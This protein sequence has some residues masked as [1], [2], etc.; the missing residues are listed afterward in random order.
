MIDLLP[1]LWSSLGAGAD[2]LVFLSHADSTHDAAARLIDEMD[3][4]EASLGPTVLLAVRQS[5]GRGRGDHTWTSP[6]GGLYLSW[7]SSGIPTSRVARLPMVAAAAAWQALASV[8]LEG[9][10]IKWPNDILHGGR[11]LAGLL[12]TARHGPPHWATVSL[13][14]NLASAPELAADASYPAGCLADALGPRTWSAWVEPIVASFVAELTKALSDPG[15][16]LSLWRAALIHR[17]G[18]RVAVRL[19]SG[20]MVHGSFRGVTADGFLRLG[21]G[22]SERVVSTGDVYPALESAAADQEGSE[23]A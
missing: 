14:V 13:G 20:E 3:D 19:A 1:R 22:D 2:N 21:E 15:P 6:E 23:T 11:K 9:H 7:L 5:A 8:G 18:D 4:D 10:G 12:V 16:A 17:P